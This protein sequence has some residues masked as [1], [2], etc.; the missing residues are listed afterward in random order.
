MDGNSTP[1]FSSGGNEEEMVGILVADNSKTDIRDLLKE[2]MATNSEIA[3][4][5]QCYNQTNVGSL[6]RCGNNIMLLIT[7]KIIVDDDDDFLRV[8]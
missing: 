1:P 2:T 7:G 5:L 8:Y 6:S 3:K 4:T